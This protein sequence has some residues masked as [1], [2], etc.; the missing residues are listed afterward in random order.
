MNQETLYILIPL[1]AFALALLLGL[2]AFGQIKKQLLLLG[3][4]EKSLTQTANK[5]FILLLILCLIIIGLLFFI[6]FE[7][8]VQAILGCCAALAVKIVVQDTL[9]QRKNGIYQNGLIACGNLYLKEDF[10]S[11]PSF[12]YENDEETEESFVPDNM[13]KAVTNSKGVIYLEFANAEDCK[14]ACELLK[15]WKL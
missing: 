6:R 13:L 9:L 7:L 2:S 4:C 5:K 12:N 1:C 11:F 10:L 14:T 8:V 3:K 15:K